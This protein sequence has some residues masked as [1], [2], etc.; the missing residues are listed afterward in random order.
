MKQED[1]ND[2]YRKVAKDYDSAFSSKSDSGSGYTF[3]GR[4]GAEALMK[5]MDLQKQD[6]LVDLGA[7]TCVTAGN[8]GCPKI[9]LFVFDNF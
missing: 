1:L 9:I 2:H 4:G 8:T 5:M 3:L 6:K 7:G